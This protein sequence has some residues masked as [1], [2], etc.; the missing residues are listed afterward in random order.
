MW[1]PPGPP[2]GA[3]GAGPL[4]LPPSWPPGLP[5][6]PGQAGM[7]QAAPPPA[8]PTK[9]P[10]GGVDVPMSADELADW[11]ARVD[12]ARAARKAQA[13]RWEQLLKA[14]LPAK[15][16]EAGGSVT[17]NSNIHFRNTEQKKAQLTPRSV[18]LILTPLGPL[19][20]QTTGP[21][22]QVHTAEDVVAIKQAVLKKLL[23]ADGINAK[24][25]LEEQNFDV[26]QVSGMSF[27]MISYE[28]DTVPVPHTDPLTGL[29]STI[30]VPI[31]E[32]FSWTRF[33]PMKGLIPDDWRSTRFDEA[34]WLGME[35]VLP[36]AQAI[37]RY[38]LPEDFQSNASLDTRVFEA[39]KPAAARAEGTSKLVEGVMIW[40]YAAPF[41]ESVAHRQL[42]R[43]LVLIKGMDA[44]AKH[45]N[46]PYQTLGPDGK[47]TADSMIGNPI[48]ILTLRDLADSAYIPSDAAMT[49]PLVRQE[50]TWATQDIALRDANVP[51][52]LYDEGITE[53]IAKLQEAATGEGAPVTA[54]TLVRGIEGLIAPLPRV[55]RANA[56]VQGR[57]A[58]RQ[59]ISETLGLGANQGGSVNDKVLSATEISS[60]NATSNVRL[61]GEQA[62]ETAY[63]LAAVRKI[64]A[65]VQRFATDLDYVQWVGRDGQKRLTAWDQTLIAGRYA[66]DL[67]PDA[68]LD[69]DMATKRQQDIQLANILGNAPETNR[70]EMLRDLAR[71]FGKDPS[72]LIQAPPPKAPEPPK[73]TLSFTG[74]DLSPLSPQQPIVLAIMQAQGVQV[75]TGALEQAQQLGVAAQQ[76]AAMLAAVKAP[77]TTAHGG[78]MTGGGQMEPISKHAGDVTGAPVGRGPM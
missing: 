60:A 16:T 34:P 18:E 78:A 4:G 61:K 63:L 37:R 5:V 27:S 52:F 53:A 40:Y 22:G 47:L 28:C 58:I 69:L 74:L 11:W 36:L 8:A 10:D 20:D 29:T 6:S 56:D 64:D 72:K 46:S 12:A 1:P 70:T 30:E 42:M 24:R 48:H 3:P 32:A 65:L 59:A 43:R 76:Q 23:G 39:T 75:P 68:A 44:P 73:L 2:G 15:T 51:R 25:L 41:D 62:R 77:P 19:Q 67:H 7:P 38:G 49:D 55:E 50:N 13:D 54:G 33:S 66:Y 21:D 57:S 45:T 31:Y 71:E 14:Y 35:F 17:L 26:L 9:N